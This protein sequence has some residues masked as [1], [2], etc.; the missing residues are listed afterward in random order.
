[1]LYY[2]I[3]RFNA[4]TI[5]SHR[6][7]KKNPKIIWNYKRTQI[8]IMILMSKN[9]VVGATTRDLKLYIRVLVRKIV[10]YWHK[11]QTDQWNRI[12]DPEINRQGYG[13]I[14]KDF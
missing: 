3:C 5:N 10:W 2:Q 1:M 11:K 13:Y 4:I 12:E 9:T 14:I 7:R 6:H 8:A